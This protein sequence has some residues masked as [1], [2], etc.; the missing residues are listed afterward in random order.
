[1]NRAFLSLPKECGIDTLKKYHKTI[2]DVS[3]I[4]L[5]DNWKWI[6]TYDKEWTLAHTSWL[7]PPTGDNKMPSCECGA[8]HTSFNNHHLE[9]CPLYK[10]RV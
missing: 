1:M 6:K 3:D 4:H 7:L 9:W 8:K 2:V 10:K 5:R